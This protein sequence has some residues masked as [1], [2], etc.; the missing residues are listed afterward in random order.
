MFDDPKGPIEHFSWARFVIAGQ[1]HSQSEEERV[2]KGKDIRL[3]GREVTRWKERK[4]HKLTP[5]M[6]TGVYDQEIEVLVIGIGVDGLIE[7][8]PK[9]KRAIEERG[10][11]TL[12]LKR[13]PEACRTYNRL[14]H[15][16]RRV[17]LLAHGTC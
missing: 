3:I 7:V 11:S 5:E 2:G 9:V 16:G 17:A 12:I 4:G 15:E 13:T 6:I 14:F 1:E 10:I 8:P